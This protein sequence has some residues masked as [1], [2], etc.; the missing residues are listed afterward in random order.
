[1]RFLC[2]LTM[3][4]CTVGLGAQDQANPSILHNEIYNYALPYVEGRMIE[5]F[6]AWETTTVLQDE[7]GEALDVHRANLALSEDTNPVALNKALGGY[8]IQSEE[9]AF[10]VSLLGGN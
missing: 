2:F 8:H 5:G 6:D 10:F 9:F 3:L 1:M 4:C 7:Q